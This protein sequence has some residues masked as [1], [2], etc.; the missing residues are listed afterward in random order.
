MRLGARTAWW[1]PILLLLSACGTDGTSED[2]DAGDT[3]GAPDAGRT[4]EASSAADPGTVGGRPEARRPWDVTPNSVGGIYFGSP[5]AELLEQ[6]TDPI[7]PALL[8][9]SCGFVEPSGAPDG[10][11]FLVENGQVVRADVVSGTARTAEGAAIGD[12][13]ARIEELYPTLRRG[14]HKYTTGSYLVV[15]PNAPADTLHRYVFETDGTSVTRFRAGLFPP[16][17]Y[18]EGCG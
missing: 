16:V 17:E 5:V 1:V 9:G 15:L 12:T 14:P 10:L 7:D 18:V 11:T 3:G 13:E 8:R 6:T 4:P 2:I